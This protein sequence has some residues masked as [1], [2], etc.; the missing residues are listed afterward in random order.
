VRQE[1][2]E[3]Q[4][5]GNNLLPQRFAQAGRRGGGLLPEE[6]KN[7]ADFYDPVCLKMKFDLR[8]K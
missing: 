8:L 6:S 1:I 2:C 4:D 7:A 3:S 5:E